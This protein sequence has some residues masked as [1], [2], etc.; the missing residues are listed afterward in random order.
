LTKRK[1]EKGSSKGT[2]E[3]DAIGDTSTT[4]RKGKAHREKKIS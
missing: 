2:R 1:E 3:D 4:L